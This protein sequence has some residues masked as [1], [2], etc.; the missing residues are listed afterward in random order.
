MQNSSKGSNIEEEDITKIQTPSSESKIDERKGTKLVDNSNYSHI[1]QISRLSSTKDPI[2][3]QMNKSDEPNNELDDKRKV[4]IVEKK[5]SNE[6][7][8]NGLID[9]IKVDQIE[10]VQLNTRKRK[11]SQGDLQ[12]PKKSSLMHE[13]DEM[14]LFMERLRSKMVETQRHK[15][16]PGR[17]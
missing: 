4:D 1:V 16:G 9:T 8:I 15:T 7:N 3:N 6:F 2:D 13:I 14:E 10:N 5:T 11:I 12:E 17:N